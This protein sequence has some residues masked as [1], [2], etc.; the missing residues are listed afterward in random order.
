M[1][2]RVPLTPRVHTAGVYVLKPPFSA[3]IDVVY[4]ADAVV[5]FR[6]LKKDGV[7]IFTEYYQKHKLTTADMAAD[8]EVNASIVTLRAGD[9]TLIEVPDTYIN[10]YPGDSGMAHT[11]QVLICDLGLIP[12]TM[13][14]DYIRDDVADILRNTIGVV[15][16]VTLAIAPVRTDLTYSQYIESERRRLANVST[17]ESKDE[18]ITKLRA[19]VADLTDR[20]AQLEQ[21]VIDL[22][23]KK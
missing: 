4:T 2:K 5:T 19:A 9:G 14:V 16:D 18:L 1:S 12:E 23:E 22:N 15:S 10:S 21:I 11:R 13:N 8:D 7:D 20:N 17:Y 3:S 6:E